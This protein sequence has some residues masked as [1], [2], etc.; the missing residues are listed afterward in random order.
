MSERE[1]LE[2]ALTWIERNVPG[3][4]QIVAAALAGL[5]PDEVPCLAEQ[6]QQPPTTLI[7]GAYVGLYTGAEGNHGGCRAEMEV[8]NNENRSYMD[9]RRLVVP[10]D[11]EFARRHGQTILSFQPVEVVVTF[12]RPTN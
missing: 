5:R 8:G 6:P 12:R 1:R 9:V 2:A 10:L 11:I 4:V 7:A 3:G